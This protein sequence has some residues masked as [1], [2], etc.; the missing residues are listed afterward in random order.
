MLVHRLVSGGGSGLR[1]CLHHDVLSRIVRQSEDKGKAMIFAMISKHTDYI[2][3]KIGGPYY[4]IASY[5]CEGSAARRSSRLSSKRC[6]PT[7]SYS[8]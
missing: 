2:D 7:Y 3:V 6:R 4:R 1:G 5:F 8:R